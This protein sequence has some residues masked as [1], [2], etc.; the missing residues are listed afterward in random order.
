MPCQISSWDC[1]QDSVFIKEYHQILA[2][3]VSQ[4]SEIGL[5]PGCSEIRGHHATELND[6]QGFYPW[7]LKNTVLINFASSTVL[8]LNIEMYEGEDLMKLFLLWKIKW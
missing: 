1:I 3:I 5:D 2:G 7:L 8:I 4:I 6:S